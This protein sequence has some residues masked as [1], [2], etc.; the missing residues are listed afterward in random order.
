MIGIAPLVAHPSLELRNPTGIATVV[1]DL[2]SDQ[3]DYHV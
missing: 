1:G 3:E 2:C